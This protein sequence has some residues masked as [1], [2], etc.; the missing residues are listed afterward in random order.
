[1]FGI[2][3]SVSRIEL[4]A[5]FCLRKFF[6]CPLLGYYGIDFYMALSS[7]CFISFSFF[8]SIIAFFLLTGLSGITS[9]VPYLS[10]IL[11]VVGICGE[12]GTGRCRGQET[13][14]RYA[15]PICLLL[16]LIIGREGVGDNR[17]IT[18]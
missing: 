11:S 6:N 1:M 2:S 7:L 4:L 5:I 10:N 12:K 9:D 14:F 8:M 18:D 16:D 17:S 13:E 15:L 3:R